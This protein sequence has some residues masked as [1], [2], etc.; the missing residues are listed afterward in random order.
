M[1]NK[2]CKRKGALTI[3][4]VIYPKLSSQLLGLTCL[5]QIGEEHH[6]NLLRH[7]IDILIPIQS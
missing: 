4:V 1:K 6:L 7:L 3:H 2:I 5:F